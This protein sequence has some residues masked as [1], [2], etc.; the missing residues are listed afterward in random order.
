MPRA[1]IRPRPRALAALVAVPLSVLVGLAALGAIGRPAAWGED[2]PAVEFSATR[3]YQQVQAIATGPHVAGSAANDRVREHLLTELRRIGLVPEVQDTVSVQGGD[4]SSSAGGIGLARVR[5]VV[6]LIPGSASTGRVIVVA[7]YD[8]VQTGP[9]GN[10]DAAGTST[11]LETARV[12]TE[13]P[14]LRNDVV[15]VLTDAEE[16]CL[17]GAKAFVDQH[18][19][20]RNGGVVLNVEARGSSGPAITFET[21]RNDARLIDTYAGVPK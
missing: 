4:L 9:G 18:P 17:C 21:S 5:N 15:L 16:A 20:A 1:L 11:V 13:G 14:H 3:A 19:L 6:S 10:D 12:L 7:H 2:A 8:S